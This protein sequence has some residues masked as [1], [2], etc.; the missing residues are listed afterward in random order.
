[1][2]VY[3][4]FMLYCTTLLDHKLTDQ[5]TMLLV[6]GDGVADICVAWDVVWDVVWDVWDVV[7]L[8]R[9][10]QYRTEA[11]HWPIVCCM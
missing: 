2:S 6:V 11:G 1:M 10:L 4:E 5:V 9:W 7:W 3:C 8:D